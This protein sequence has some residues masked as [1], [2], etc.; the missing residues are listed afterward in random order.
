MGTAR[1]RCKRIKRRVPGGRVP[2]NLGVT[3]QVQQI[4]VGKI[5]ERQPGATTARDVA[6]RI[7]VP[8]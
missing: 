4:P 6:E 1:S 3:A 8:G 5:R 7:E 2:D